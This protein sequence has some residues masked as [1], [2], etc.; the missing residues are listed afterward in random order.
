[1]DSSAR[2][3]HIAIARIV[4]TRGHRGEVLAEIHTDFPARFSLLKRVWVEFPD[5]RRECL[6]LENCWEH[7]GMEVLKFDAVNS[8]SEAELLVGA[9]VEIESEH[10]VSLPEG[11]FWDH[12]L[13]GCRLRNTVGETLGEVTGVLRIAGNS[14]L[15]V[16][17]K[18]GEFLVPVVA[19]ICREISIARR[20]IVVVLPD[21]LI[22]INN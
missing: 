12:E 1:M 11:T 8:I 9:W 20:E 17:G 21:G 5:G 10:A 15:V 22:D 18:S 16:Q 3:S 19:A 2:P 14:Q 6:E 4:R 13:T 7:R